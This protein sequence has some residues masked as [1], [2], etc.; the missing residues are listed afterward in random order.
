MGE[1]FLSSVST[2]ATKL[3]DSRQGKT[4]DVITL[5]HKPSLQSS[6][7]LLGLLQRASIKASDPGQKVNIK[8]T[9]WDLE[10]T[11]NG[12]TSD[13]LR[14]ILEYV[15]ARRAGGIMK[16]AK[17]EADAMRR[18]KARPGDFVWPLVR[19]LSTLRPDGLTHNVRNRR[20]IGATAVW[21][22]RPMTWIAVDD[23]AILTIDFS[24]MGEDTPEILKM[25]EWNGK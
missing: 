23:G 12:P 25:L 7:R 11:E 1:S 13:Q 17:D 15:G 24:V 18:L 19:T 2:V 5:F 9:E 4:L 3:T 10:V 22:S 20:W 6:T 21:V 16:G 14:S 8:R